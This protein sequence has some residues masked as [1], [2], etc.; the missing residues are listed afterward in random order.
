MEIRV[1]NKTIDFKIIPLTF[2]CKDILSVFYN[3]K[4]KKTLLQ[5]FDHVRYLRL[6][7]SFVDRYKDHL[8]KRLS[9]FLKSLKETNDKNYL[10]FLNKY[11]DNN[12]CEFRISDN[13]TDKGIYCYIADDRIKYVGRCTDNFKKRINQGYGKINPKNCFIDGQATNCHLNSLI[14]STNNVKFGVHIMTDQTT[15]Q[16]RELEKL[17]LKSDTFEWNIQKS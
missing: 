8:D 1:D 12:F 16:I 14:N 15:E 4:S 11:G 6:K 10:N 5:T 3:L 7:P 2:V 17:I 9:D 13:L